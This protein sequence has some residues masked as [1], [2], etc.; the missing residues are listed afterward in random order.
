QTVVILGASLDL[1]VGYMIS[2]SSL[3]AADV[4]ADDPGKIFI[5]ILAVGGVGLAVG[6]LNGLIITKLRVNP[7]IATLG[8]ALILR[9]MIQKDYTRV[10]PGI[11]KDLI[12]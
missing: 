5:G 3:I 9:T 2:Y 8:M 4:M 7:F 10:L 11:P 6:L 1:S 12:D